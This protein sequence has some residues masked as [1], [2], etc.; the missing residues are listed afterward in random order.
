MITKAR[1][2]VPG[3]AHVITTVLKIARDTGVDNQFL[4]VAQSPSINV[5][6]TVSTEDVRL[7]VTAGDFLGLSGSAG[8]LFCNTPSAGDKAVAFAGDAA[9]GSTET[10]SPPIANLSIP[11]IATIEPDADGDG[12]GD[13]TQDLCPQVRVVPDRLPRR[14]SSTRSPRR[15]RERSRS[16]RCRPPRRR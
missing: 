15:P 13:I 12:Y 3:A 10:Y 8:T 9:L 6:N 1:F 4:I 2:N 16:S 11:V 14:S 5:P 7:P